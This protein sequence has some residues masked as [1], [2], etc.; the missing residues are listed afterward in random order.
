MNMPPIINKLV[1]HNYQIVTQRPT[2]MFFKCNFEGCNRM[3]ASKKTLGEH[4]RTHNQNR[5]YTW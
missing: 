3:F 2:D 1:V 4:M 5:P